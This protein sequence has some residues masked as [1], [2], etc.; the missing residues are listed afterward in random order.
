MTDRNL[1]IRVSLSA[2]NRLSGPLNAATRAAAGLSSQIRNTHNSVRSLQSQALTFERLTNSV[3]KTSDSYDEAKRKVKALRDQMPPFAQQ[4][5]EQRRVLEA[6]RQERDRYGRAL[7]KE[8]QKLRG[9]AAELYRHGISAR[10]SSDVTGQVTRRTEAYN[11]QLA[12]Q[13]RRLT[14]V[15]RAQS[16]YAQ[17]KETRGKLISAGAAGM[18]AGAGSLY[19]MSRFIAPGRDFDARM[20]NVRALT[21]LGNASPQYNMLREQAKELGASTAFTATDAAMGQKFLATAGFTP[22][23]IKAALPGILNMALAGEVDLGESAD[24]GAKMLSQFRLNPDQMDRLSDVLTATFTGST[25]NLRELSEAMVYAG[26]LAPQLG[27]SLE[28][29]A[30]M[31]GVMA[32]NGTNGSMAGTALRA[33][34]SRLVAP[35]GGAADAMATLGIKIKKSNGELRDTDDILKEM[36]VS[37]RQFDQPSQILMKKAIFGEEA[38]IGMGNVL[39]GMLNGKYAEKK[40]NNNNA[41]GR[42]K[43]IADTNMDSW[44]GDLKNL[45]SAWE[46]LRIEVKEQVDPVLRE[47]T[48]RITGILRRIT[49][50][51]KAHPDLTKALAMGAATIGIIVTG[52]G[53]LALAAA[54]VIVPFAAFRLSLF[55]LTRGGG[56]TALFPALGGLSTRL[57]GLLPSL[58]GVSRSVT[59]WV[60]IFNNARTA[61]SGLVSRGITALMKGADFAKRGLLMVFTRPMTAITMLGNG[62]KGLATGGLGALRLAFQAA[63]SVIGGGL[64]LLFSPLGLLIAVIVVAALLIWKYW[65]PIKAWFSGFFSGLMEEIAPV[66]DTLAAA[67]APFAPIFDA[68]GNAIKKVW[69]W[70]KSLFEPVNTSAEGLKAATEAGQTFGRLVGK[71]I[72]GVVDVIA[73]VAKGVGWLLEK[74]GM[75][76][77]ATKAAAEAANAMGPVNLPEVQ[78]SVKWVWDDKA[79]KM[80]QQ[81]WTPTPA[82]KA[83]TKAG[84]KAEENKPKVDTPALPDFG[85]QMYEPGKNKKKGKTAAESVEAAGNAAAQTD[86]NKLGDI[87]F[88]NRPPV[89]PIEGVYQEPRLQQPSLL[90]RLTDKLQPML[91]T[92]SGIPVPVTPARAGNGN[93]QDDR[94]IINLHFHGVDMQ[95]SRSISEMVKTEVEKIMQKKG[96]RRRSSLYDED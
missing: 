82:N 58:G 84:E 85:P 91:P 2:A 87:V 11:R 46:G 34:L 9:V 75:I 44:D 63:L 67:F 66:R 90:S 93:K 92:L 40:T 80:V 55:M 79:K 21:N 3:K 64:S 61:I 36:A 96:V 65:E 53:A 25:T 57:R 27:I 47:V 8:K 43:K 59:G 33:G 14:A 48:Q 42:A 26:S 4:T 41:D 15:T 70:F 73:A 86:P 6:A 24:M 31:V 39:D 45:T 28:S 32:D 94:Y 37:L 5:E 12:E 69:E 29:M 62:I 77:D 51:T 17:A 7:D 20:A 56:L 19:G 50:W 18:A 13:Q 54:A 60:P 78:K 83:I 95:N 68:I 1:N 88:K 23:S 89:I 74:L 10:S 52:L 76:P 16:R 49:E 30:A 35:T 38:M 72:A 81:E 71:A 22:E